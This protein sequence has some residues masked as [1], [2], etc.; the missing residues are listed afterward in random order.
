MISPT[1][2]LID[3]KPPMQNIP[4]RTDEGKKIKESFLKD[5]VFMTEIPEDMKDI[6]YYG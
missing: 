2:R 4:I 6:S 5:I 1:G 3:Y